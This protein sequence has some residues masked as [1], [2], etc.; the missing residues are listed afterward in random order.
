[1]VVF[2]YNNTMHSSTQQ[3]H[4][5]TNHDLH[6]KFDIQGM[7]KIMNP[8]NKKWALWLV[9]IWTKLVSNLDNA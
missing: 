3:T 9:D 4:L 1:M 7:N 8:T 2:A 6:P 5:F